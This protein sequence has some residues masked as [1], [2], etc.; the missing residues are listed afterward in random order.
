AAAAPSSGGIRGCLLLLAPVGAGA[1][2]RGV[3]LFGPGRPPRGPVHKTTS[4]PGG[5]W[6]L[7]AEAQNPRRESGARGRGRAPPATGGGCCRGRAPA[8]TCDS[9]SLTKH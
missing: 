7:P 2:L 3:G 5:P 1:T 6:R 9:C 4:P 8:C